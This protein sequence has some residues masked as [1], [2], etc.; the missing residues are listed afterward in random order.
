MVSEN[1][2]ATMDVVMEVEENLLRKCLPLLRRPFAVVCLPYGGVNLFSGEKL[3]TQG[4][5]D[6]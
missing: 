6:L 1:K 3:L 4:Y 2:G 5:D